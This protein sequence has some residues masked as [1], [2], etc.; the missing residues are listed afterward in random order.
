MYLSELLLDELFD[1]ELEHP[2]AK[3]VIKNAIM[4]TPIFDRFIVS[5]SY[6]NE[7]ILLKLYQISL[8][9]NW[10]KKLAQF[11]EINR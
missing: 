7:F 6:K 10:L 1:D 2:T 9:K 11:F 8:V 3:K 5:S 4:A